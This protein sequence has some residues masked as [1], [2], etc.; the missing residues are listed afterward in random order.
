MLRALGLEEED[1]LVYE[2]LLVDGNQSAKEIARVTGLGPSAVAAA[3]A[4]LE[5]LGL[6]GRLPGARGGWHVPAPSLALDALL[7]RRQ[8]QVDRARTEIDAFVRD[9]A[10]RG[11]RQAA[12]PSVELV[13]GLEGARQRWVQIQRS[14]RSEVCVFDLP[15]HVMSTQAANPQQLLA[16]DRGV[17][18]RVVYDGRSL[19]VPGRMDIVRQCVA[20]GELART[21]EGLPLK[22][23]IVDGSS[24]LTYDVRG[25][26]ITDGMIVHGGPLLAG[27]VRLFELVWDTAAPLL[28]DTADLP[29]GLESRDRAILDLLAA[30]AS[31][32]AIARRMGVGV[33]TVGRRISR[34]SADLSASSR[35]QLALRAR[36]AGWV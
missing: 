30:G 32:E 7:E 2:R 35:F 13:G 5:Q 15:P 18:Y 4:H 36:D 29:G 8:E 11:L 34:M 28:S 22:L 14:A 1:S 16:L 3:L 26:E 27:L 17:R 6:V 21:A 20:A 10:R 31:D 33:R 25:D 19:D 23:M 24:A 9:L 12:A